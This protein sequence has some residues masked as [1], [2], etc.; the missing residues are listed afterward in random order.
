[1]CLLCGSQLWSSPQVKVGGF[2]AIRAGLQAD[3]YIEAHGIDKQKLGYGE[4]HVAGSD[5]D[6]VSRSDG[7]FE[8]D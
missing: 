5:A 3:T 2:K 1:M 7:R 8:V 4:L 6:M